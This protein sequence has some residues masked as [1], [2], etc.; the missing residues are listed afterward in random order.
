[1]RVDLPAASTMAGITPASYDCS[2][3]LPQSGIL[4][5]NGKIAADD[6]CRSPHPVS[7]LRH[8]DGNARPGTGYA[9][10]PR[11]V[12]GLSTV[13][14]PLLVNLPAAQSRETQAGDRATIL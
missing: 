13:R 2:A 6:R 11:S 4:L 8:A 1:M 5:G 7:T 12:L 10:G 14:P 9:L 3:F